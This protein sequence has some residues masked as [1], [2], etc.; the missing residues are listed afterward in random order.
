VR[1]D[2]EAAVA[3][4]RRELLVHCY[5]MLGSPQDAEDLLQETLLRAW[6]SADSY[7]AGRASLRTWLY[8]IATN[9]CLNALESRRARPLPSGIGERFEDPD[10]AF[11]PG[12]EVPWLMP[13]PADPAATAVE[14]SRLRLALVAA[15]QLLP[16]RQRAALILGEVLDVPAAEVADALGMT[17]AAVNSARQR[18]RARLAA[19]GMDPEAATEPAPEQRAVV[20]RYV[21]AFERADV[22]GLTALLADEVILEMPPMWNW[23]AGTAAYAGFM[24]RV[25]RTR[26]TAWSSVPLW[27]NG[28]AGFAAYC[29]GELHTV[30]ILTVAGGLV[31]RTSVFQDPGVLAL[32]DLP[33]RLR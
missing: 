22:P 5:R 16:A 28:E 6:R 2:F 26:G 27:A 14:R 24:E 12:L 4:Y 11:A 33:Q 15:L 29:D 8:R 13:L 23:Y 3:P 9:A 25:Y 30:Q 19:V 31:R 17:T 20:E 10:A 21:A 1:D 18:A 7:D 32:F